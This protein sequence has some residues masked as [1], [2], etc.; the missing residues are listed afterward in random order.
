M[1]KQ[2]YYAVTTRMTFEKTVLIPVEHAK[3]MEDAIDIVDSGVETARIDLLNSE[4]DCKTFPCPY[5][6][7]NTDGIYEF[8][9]NE[10]AGY[11]ILTRDI[12]STL[13]YKDLNADSGEE[14]LFTV[15]E[16]WAKEWFKKRNYCFESHNLNYTYEDAA[17]MYQD[18]VEA[19]MLISAVEKKANEASYNCPHITCEKHEEDGE[20]VMS[21]YTTYNGCDPE[22]YSYE[23]L[24]TTATENEKMN[25][26]KNMKLTAAV[27][28]SKEHLPFYIYDE[29]KDTILQKSM[30]H[31]NRKEYADG[32]RS[33]NQ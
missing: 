18:A 28:S 12:Y 11:Q 5:V 29:E 31:K 6:N 32:K 3:N 1:L 33:F 10:S 4:A 13:T 8:P 25:M 30:E 24:E 23:K 17:E 15:P 26:W 21:V 2:K 9:S 20:T 22:F 7:T 14:I 19:D 27:L 16:E